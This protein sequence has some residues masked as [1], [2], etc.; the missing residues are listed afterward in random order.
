MHSILRLANQPQAAALGENAN[1]AHGQQRRHEPWPRPWHGEGHDR[2]PT[3]GC[4]AQDRRMAERV[5]QPHQL[6]ASHDPV[7]EIVRSSGP[8]R[9]TGSVKSSPPDEARGQGK[10]RHEK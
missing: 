9:T 1:G 3:Q 8:E 4:P 2:N 5:F 7:R 6:P 10:I